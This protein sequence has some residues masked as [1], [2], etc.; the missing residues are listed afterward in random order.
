MG[1]WIDENTYQF[2]DEKEMAAALGIDL[3][4]IEG[5]YAEAYHHMSKIWNTAEI[6]ISLNKENKDVH[7]TR[8]SDASSLRRK[9]DGYM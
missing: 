4:T 1:Y 6:D 5:D 8:R 2:E 3:D 9:S 7:A